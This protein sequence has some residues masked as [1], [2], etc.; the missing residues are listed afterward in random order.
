MAT[1][2]RVDIVFVVGL[3]TAAASEPLRL[4]LISLPLVPPPRYRGFAGTLGRREALSGL[5]L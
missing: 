5:R 4:S 2:A 3:G 1:P